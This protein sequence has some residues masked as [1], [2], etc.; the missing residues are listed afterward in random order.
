M[1]HVGLYPTWERDKSCALRTTSPGQEA[2]RNDKDNQLRLAAVIERHIADERMMGFEHG[3]HVEMQNLVRRTEL[4]GQRGKIC[5]ENRR[6]GRLLVKVG[7][8]TFVV[9]RPNLRQL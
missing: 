9:Q 2:H 3:A 4:N 1:S 5:G 8:C 7:S 6:N